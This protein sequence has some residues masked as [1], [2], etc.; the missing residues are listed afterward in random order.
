MKGG[1]NVP[2]LAAVGGAV[3]A[4]FGASAVTIAA[5]SGFATIIGG[6]VVGAAVGGLYAA[7]TGGD[8]LQGVLYGA[9]GGA[10]IGGGYAAFVYAGTGTGFGTA[11][12]AAGSSAPA[13]ATGGALGAVGNT[14]EGAMSATLGTEGA[15]TGITTTGTGAFESVA[16]E[17]SIFTSEHVIATGQ[18][19]SLGAGLLKGATGD[20]YAKEK[21]KSDEKISAETL[22]A[23]K[24]MNARNNDTALAQAKIQAGSAAA[25]NASQEKMAA[26]RLEFD[27]SKFS[28]EFDEMQFI[29]RENRREKRKAKNDFEGGLNDAADMTVAGVQTLETQQRRRNL[30][31]PVWYQKLQPAKPEAPAAPAQSGILRTA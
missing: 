16:T 21:I 26:A 23:Q 20:D 5:F 17:A 9:V 12:T 19:A 8:I 3:M 13:T 4:A 14:G 28:K 25:Q 18:V 31:S 30:P 11:A 6:M 1:T 22:E 15:T 24:E 10:V 27:Q 2:W 7:V 29:D